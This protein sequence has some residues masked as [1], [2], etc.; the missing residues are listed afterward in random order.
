MPNENDSN[1]RIVLPNRVYDLLSNGAKDLK[2][3]GVH[4]KVN[5]AKLG[6]AIIEIF[7]EKYWGKDRDQIE[8]MFFDKRTYLKTLIEKSNSEEDLSTSII[9][10]L[11]LSKGKRLAKQ[12]SDS[13]SG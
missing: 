8:K 4:F 3:K 9:E 1:R 2:E 5:E 6:A 12:N 11:Q 7:F 13:S 10:Y